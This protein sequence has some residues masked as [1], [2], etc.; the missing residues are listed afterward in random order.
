MGTIPPERRFAIRLF[1]R[2]L[3][4]W[5][6]RETEPDYVNEDR[7][8]WA[9]TVLGLIGQ[10]HPDD[11]EMMALESLARTTLALCDNPQDIDVIARFEEAGP[12]HRWLVDDTAA[13][14]SMRFP[15]ADGL[16]WHD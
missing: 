5:K 12:L 14:V 8:E 9:H 3:A 11:L 16:Y 15:A 2:S 7:R 1:L 6:P 13:A 4:T 10:D